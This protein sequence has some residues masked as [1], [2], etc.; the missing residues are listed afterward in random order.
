V[1]IKACFSWNNTDEQAFSFLLSAIVSVH[2]I[3]PV[4]KIYEKARILLKYIA[5]DIH[6]LS[7]F[8]YI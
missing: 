5:R 1:Y 2:V 4:M 6:L 8:C 7:K 3:A